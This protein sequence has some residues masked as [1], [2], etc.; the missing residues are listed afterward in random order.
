MISAGFDAHERDPLAQINLK[1][2][3]YFWVTGE[4]LSI[5]TNYCGGN[6]I[7]LLEGGYDLDAL[8]ES[9][10]AHVRALMQF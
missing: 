9:S 6:V 3:D 1:S 10:Q 2:D 8:K 7:S 5:A 4:L